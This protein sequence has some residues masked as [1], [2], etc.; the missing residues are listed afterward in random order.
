MPDRTFTHKLVSP[1]DLAPSRDG[2]EVIGVFNPGVAEL[3]DETVIVG[4]VVERPTDTHPGYVASPRL[5]EHGTLL[6][7]ELPEAQY[8]LSDRRTVTHRVD[9]SRRLRFISHFRVFRSADGKSIDDP[10]NAVVVLPEGPYETYGIEDPRVTQIGDLFYIT[11]VAVSPR[12]VCTCLM[13]TTDF[14]TFHRHGIVLPP[15]NKDVVLFPEKLLGDYVA[16]HRPM[17]M[18]K[19]A[20]PA[21]WLARSQNLMQWGAHERMQGTDLG[22][23]R[24]GGGTP[25]VRTR[26]GWLIIY[27]AKHDLPD[28]PNGEKRFEYVAH[29]MLLHPDNPRT[30][31]GMATAPIMTPQEDFETHGFVDGV[32]FPTGIIERD[33][34]FWVYYGAADEH[35]AVCGFDRRELLA[36]CEPLEQAAEV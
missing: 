22:G 23:L 29:A 20:E 31:V 11:Y 24:I 33:E 5:D 26:D 4:R 6:I 1:A 16:I 19:F 27:H 14:V 17:P 3:N 18:I 10:S 34:Q 36:A 8:D 21:M 7:D 32:V 15:D 2:L 30:V 28:A 13:S 12:G 35:V 25:P 9:G